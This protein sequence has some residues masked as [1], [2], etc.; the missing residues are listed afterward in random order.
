MMALTRA[1]EIGRGQ[2]VNVYTESKYAFGVIRAH[3]AIWKE[4]GV[5]NSQGN[6]IKYGQEILKLL[7]AVLEAKQVAKAAISCN[8][9]CPAQTGN[10]SPDTW[11]KNQHETSPVFGGGGSIGGEV[12]MFKWYR[13]GWWITPNQQLLTMDKMIEILLKKLHEETHVGIDAMISSI[14]KYAIGPKM[15]SSADLM[16]RR[17]QTC[18]TNNPKSQR[19]PPAG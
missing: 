14:K 3:G 10:W 6:S 12:E 2:R 4:R 9:S 16:P 19:K 5:L 13:E 15:Q 17:C 11:W 18:C 1:P 7:H 8:K